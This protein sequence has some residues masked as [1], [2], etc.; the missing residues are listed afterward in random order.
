MKKIN[1]FIMDS[2]NKGFYT[3]LIDT[4]KEEDRYY[5]FAIESKKKDSSVAISEFTGVQAIR[6]KKTNEIYEVSSHGNFSRD[7]NKEINKDFKKWQPDQRWTFMMNMDSRII[8]LGWSP[9]SAE[10]Y[11]KVVR[12]INVRNLSPKKKVDD[13]FLKMYERN[14]SKYK[15]PDDISDDD[16]RK[17]LKANIS[18]EKLKQLM[19]DGHI[20]YPK[21]FKFD[22][23]IIDRFCIQEN[24]PIY[25]PVF[26]KEVL[27]N[28]FKNNID[29]FKWVGPNEV[30]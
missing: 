6:D 28:Y 12:N 9:K 10:L 19:N 29:I 27:K 5:D 11:N 16:K 1:Q 15:H 21:T 13:H 17:K 24:D 14:S 2:L 18:K 30:N 25:T 3:N 8:G 7:K 4:F 20:F 22:D 23:L 26:F